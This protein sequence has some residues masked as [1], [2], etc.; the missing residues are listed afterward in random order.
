MPTS[1][2]PATLLRP[3]DFQPHRQQ[4]PTSHPFSAA[5]ELD[6]SFSAAIIPLEKDGVHPFYALAL[7]PQSDWGGGIAFHHPSVAR[8]SAHLSK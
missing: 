4:Q 6:N 8:C 5:F 1:A 3:V 7:H 2:D